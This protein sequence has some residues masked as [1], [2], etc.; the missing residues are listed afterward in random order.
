M[1]I[2]FITPY[3]SYPPNSGSAIRSFNIIMELSKKHNI[4]LLALVTQ[5]EVPLISQMEKY[6]HKVK[7]VE[8]YPKIIPK[9][10][11]KRL[12]FSFFGL[13]H[14]VRSFVFKEM[15][16]LLQQILR[17]KQFD[18]VQFELL[19]MSY[20][21]NYIKNIPAIL[22]EHNFEAMR[23]H[24]GIQTEKCSLKHKVLKM[25]D[26]FRLKRYEIKISKRFDEVFH[27]S[28]ID[29]KHLHKYDPTIRT[30]VIPNGVDLSYF[31]PQKS[32]E[33]EHSLVF[34]GSMFYQPNIDAMLYFYNDIFPL[35]VKDFSDVKLYIVGQKPPQEILA[36]REHPGVVVTGFVEDARPYIARANVYVCPIRIGGGSRL[37][38]LDA[39]AMGKAIVSTSVGCEGLDVEQ[40]RHLLIA[41]TPDVFASKV[42]RLLTDEKLK[43]HLES[44]GR[45]LTEQKYGW[46][47]IVSLIEERYDEVVRE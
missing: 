2:L 15:I 37:K 14:F 1:N 3:L 10:F 7:T 16:T 34:S 12:H 38:L 13:P 24:R 32:S 20:Y 6:C 42:N 45:I 17:E 41:D 19:S 5:E 26:Y 36:L 35:I 30:T 46:E 40:D 27:V 43:D 11:L 9:S 28:E 4:T 29:I 47:S 31:K 23:Y 39:M 8:I 44:E 22:N 33:E 21:V 18:L 25:A